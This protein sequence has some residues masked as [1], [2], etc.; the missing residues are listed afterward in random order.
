VLHLHAAGH[1]RDLAL[2]LARVL[3]EPPDD[4]MVAETIVV[5]SAGM[6]RWLRLELSRHLGA[7]AGRH[8]GV[9]ANLN[10][11]YPGRLTAELLHPR[12]PTDSDP[13]QL[14]RLVWIV[15]QV[16]VEG[17]G[18]PELGAITTLPDGA[19]WWGRAR[20]VADLF[21]RY[22]T[23]RPHM[24][25]Q[26]CNGHDVD[27]RG[28]RLSDDLRWQPRVW[29]AVRH[30]IGVP[31]TAETRRARLDE[32][33]A[34]DR[35]DAFGSRVSLF[36][37]SSI[38]GGSPLL[39]LLEATASHR[40]IHL[41][42]LQPS[43][44]MAANLRRVAAGADRPR[45]AQMAEVVTHAVVHPLL[46]SWAHPAHEVALLLDS[47]DQPPLPPT[48]EPA[49][50]LARLQHDLR[51]DRS[52]TKGTP[53]AHDHSITIHSCHGPTRQV[54]VLRDQLLHL[55]QADPTLTEDD[56]VVLCPD[57]EAYAPLIAGVWGP[58]APT[59]AD[60]PTP[61]A[62]IHGPPALAYRIT[63]RSLTET[64][65]LSGALGALLELLG[66]RFSSTAV[67]DFVALG[68]VRQRFG[69]NDDALA[70]IAN[71]AD[72]T[73]TKWG[74][75]GTHRVG[76]GVPATCAQ[77]SWRE[78]ID[79]V[80]L[81]VA[82]TDDD[83]SLTAGSVAPTDVEGSDVA[84]AGR[85]ADLLARLE[86]LDHAARGSRRAVDWVA[87]LQR[88]VDDL[89]AVDDALEWQRTRLTTMLSTIAANSTAH[90]EPSPVELTLADVRRLV[91]EQLAAGSRRTEFFRGGITVSSLTPLRNVPFRVVCLLGMDESAFASS[92]DDGDDLVT[93]DPQ[94]GDRNRRAEVRQALLEAV[95]AVGDHLVITR[96]G[97]SVVTNK[98]VPPSVPV[99]E[100]T[101]VLT[102]MVPDDT[103]ADVVHPRQAF[104]RR[105]FRP[106]EVWGTA[107][108]SFDPTARDAAQ[109]STSSPRARTP[110]VQGRDRSTPPTTTATD[111]IDLADLRAFLAH[112]VKYHVNQVLQVKLPRVPERARG[113]LV[114]PA[115]G[116]S[117]TPRAAAGPDLVVALDSLSK[118]Q[119]KDD[120]LANRLSSGNH[121]A[122]AERQ[123]A[124][125]GLPAGRLALSA[126]DEAS[127]VV[128]PLVA[129]AEALGVVGTTAQNVTVHVGLADGTHI[130]GS[131]ADRG[132][133]QPGPVTITPSSIS[134]PSSKL[135]GPWLDLLVLTAHDPTRP[136]WSVIV[137]PA[138]NK[139]KCRQTTL[140]ISG[141]DA[142]ERRS[143]ALDALHVV[144]DCFRRNQIEPIPLLPKVSPRL[145]RGTSF[146]NEWSSP[147]APGDGDDPYIALAFGHA[148]LSDLL[149]LPAEPDDPPGAATTRL[150][151]YA[152]YLWDAYVAS[153]AAA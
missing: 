114:R 38:P 83:E 121:E 137:S 117:G 91:G 141:N 122:F 124:T 127:T 18:N 105:N 58:S 66:S 4:P 71:W 97:H 54:E 44:A 15:L 70:T 81:G 42:L 130:G 85:F 28:Q 29:R 25:L 35:S 133:T 135:L 136:W 36:G 84:V 150:H 103:W 88:A 116:A 37:L 22:L 119:L 65:A 13:W 23:H 79:R 41:C 112:P 49:P 31:S 149:V 106:G 1:A 96:T 77:G 10:L 47:P 78:G 53:I 63:D 67:L 14:D 45:R 8:D 11:V 118:W 151:R 50:L 143:R 95:L 7:A 111:L 24:V 139:R 132:G 9:A 55:L 108:W 152:H 3:A 68:P 48:D 34:G 89:F 32:L 17:A 94:L 33:R 62:A 43:P 144:V 120:L 107:A 110:A 104:D 39:E 148:S 6:D 74:I 64:S 72:H 26:W 134:Y 46:R 123:G 61:A 86:Q 100:L 140:Q 128:E 16:L 12:G 56:I 145:A 51:A 30:R 52:P 57:L 69:F 115:R 59:G 93:R 60:R 40:D 75:D 129:A 142:S 5:P 101:D 2:Q 87:L 21:D 138:D 20:R 19:T 90:D 131:V 99:A 113:T 27:G 73:N 80:L 147:N 82:V 126:L 92:N 102:A 98:A 153:L 125:G 146:A 109:I 76:W